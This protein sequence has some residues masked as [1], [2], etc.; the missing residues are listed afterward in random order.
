MLRPRVFHGLREHQSRSVLYA[1]EAASHTLKGA[2]IVSRDPRNRVQPVGQARR[3]E[4]VDA[5]RAVRVRI[6]GKSAAMSGRRWLYDG[7]PTITPSI[8]TS[9][10]EPS[11]GIVFG[12]GVSAQPKLMTTPETVAPC[13]G[14]SM[15]PN[16]RVLAAL[17]ATMTRVP[18]VWL[19][20]ARDARHGVEREGAVPPVWQHVGQDHESPAGA[21]HVGYV[22]NAATMSGLAPSIIAAV[23]TKTRP[24]ASVGSPASGE[25]W[26]RTP[27]M[28]LSSTAQPVNATSPATVAD[29]GGVSIVPSGTVATTG[30]AIRVVMAC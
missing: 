3:I 6:P 12:C 22:G 26:I 16:G 20:P 4:L 30:A 25:R 2:R 23:P 19:W 18:M 11:E 15:V 5:Y 28:P 17:A 24:L 29:G 27:A 9:I 21:R 1:E 14:V 8:Y 10:V 13:A 7:W